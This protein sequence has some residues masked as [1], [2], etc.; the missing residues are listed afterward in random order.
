MDCVV[1][2]DPGQAAIGLVALSKAR[3][4]TPYR[5]ELA[6]ANCR[7]DRY[8][9]RRGI[10]DQIQHRVVVIGGPC[11]RAAAWRRSGSALTSESV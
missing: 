2:A 11:S 6:C 1:A 3:T 5:A 9:I 7:S 10:G 8:R 4:P